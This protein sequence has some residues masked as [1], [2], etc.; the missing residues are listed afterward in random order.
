MNLTKSLFVV[1]VIILCLPFIMTASTFL[2]YIHVHGDPVNDPENQLT[3]VN[4]FMTLA[5]FTALQVPIGF[6]PL[7]INFLSA[8]RTYI[9]N[10]Y[11]Q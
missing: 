5:L 8:V 11:T 6:L 1:M 3:T 9:F 10:G 4:A 7:T 2:I